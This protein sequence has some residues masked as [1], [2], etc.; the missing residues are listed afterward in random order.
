MCH[1]PR[2]D[3]Q[4]QGLIKLQ[5]RDQLCIRTRAVHPLI[6][7]RFRRKICR[8]DKLKFRN[9]LKHAFRSSQL[10]SIHRQRW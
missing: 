9:C 8:L 2:S 10:L 6:M 5:F 3:L 7:T 1:L 4:S